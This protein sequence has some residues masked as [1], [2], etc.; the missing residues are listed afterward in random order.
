[1]QKISRIGRLGFLILIFLFQ[2]SLQAQ[3]KKYFV[4][5]GQIVPEEKGTSSGVI[6]ITKNAKET[7]TVEI[8]KNGRFRLELEFFNEY[9][10]NF[11]YPG[12]FSK[13]IV[14][15]TDIQQ[16]VWARDNDFPPF[17]MV[18]QLLKEFEGVDKSFTL[19]PT[20]RIFYG[21]DIDNFQKEGYIADIQ[22]VEQ[23][24]TAKTKAT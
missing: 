2:L 6:E 21:K 17:P 15:N 18:V 5:S 3:N 8:P 19:K 10:L 1:M 14:V 13:I 9:Y 22:F 20:G 11:K 16:E 23:I 7:S 24:E 12:H 4:I